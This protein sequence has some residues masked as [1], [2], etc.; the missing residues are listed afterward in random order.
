MIVGGLVL[1]GAFDVTLQYLRSYALNHTTSRIDVELGARLFDHLLRLPLSYFETRPTGQTVARIRE[2]ETIRSF[3]TG[4]GLSSIID[5][6]FAVI[7]ISVLFVYSPLLATIVLASI[8]IYVAIAVVVR[9]ILRQRKTSVSI[10]VRRIGSLRSNL[11]LACR[12]SNRARNRTHL[13]QRVGR[14][15]ASDVRTSFKAVTLSNLGQ[16]AIQYVG[17][18]TT[19]L[20]ILF[21]ARAVMNGEMSIGALVAFTMIMNRPPRP[22]CGC[23]NSGRIS[24]RF[25]FQLIGLAIFQEPPSKPCQGVRQFAPARGSISVQRSEFPRST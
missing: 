17:K 10:V 24:S 14:E 1:L 7:F 22:Y 12:R 25:T 23:R 4:Q 18:A 6:L 13:E 21:G 15:A 5:L 3:L 11:L 20:V 9:P 16:N 8:P 19:A 2:L